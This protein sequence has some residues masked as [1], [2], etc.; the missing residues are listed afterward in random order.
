M[1]S[2]SSMCNIVV[3]YFLRIIL[4]HINIIIKVGQMHRD[5]IEI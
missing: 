2:A 5:F 4:K 1:R 3:R